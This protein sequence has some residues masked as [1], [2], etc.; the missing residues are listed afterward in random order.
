MVSLKS[1]GSVLF[2]GR[3][4]VQVVVVFTAEVGQVTVRPGMSAGVRGV[5]ARLIVISFPFPNVDV[6][7]LALYFDVRVAAVFPTDMAVQV[8]VFV[9]I[10]PV[11]LDGGMVQVLIVPLSPILKS[12]L[13]VRLVKVVVPLRVIVQSVVPPTVTEA[14]VQ[15]RDWMLVFR[16]G[17]VTVI[18]V[19]PPRLVV[20]VLDPMVVP[21]GMLE[22]VNVPSV[23]NVVATFPPPLFILTVIFPL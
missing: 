4:K 22:A 5:V 7:P 10:D 6:V 14:G 12:I 15:E 19:L 9:V 13:P 2:E 11:P 21:T 23:L 17:L 20:A 16:M 8:R 1:V 18:F 3:G